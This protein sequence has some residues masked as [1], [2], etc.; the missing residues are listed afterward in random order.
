MSPF[1]DVINKAVIKTKLMKLLMTLL[2][3]NSCKVVLRKTVFWC[4]GA[5]YQLCSIYSHHRVYYHCV[6]SVRIRCYSGPHAPAFGL[7]TDQNNSECGHFLRSALLFQKCR[8]KHKKNI[9]YP[10][11]MSLQNSVHLSNLT[12]S[13][14]YLA[15]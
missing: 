8:C 2:S 10:Y 4:I 7:K 13:K 9:T 14:D 12:S 3:F 15:K 1:A 5:T 11:N 6:K